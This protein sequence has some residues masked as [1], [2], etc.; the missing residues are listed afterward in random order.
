MFRRMFNIISNVGFSLLNSI[1][2]YLCL[3]P[4]FCILLK[5]QICISVQNF[6]QNHFLCPKS[7]FLSPKSMGWVGGWV[8][9]LAWYF[10]FVMFNLF[11]TH[12]KLM[13][14]DLCQVKV[15]HFKKEHKIRRYESQ[16]QGKEEVAGQIPW[17]FF[18]SSL[19]QFRLEVL[20]RVINISVFMGGELIYQK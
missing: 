13:Y 2:G 15:V 9:K 10:W 11:C 19:P 3:N 1:V 8:H 5:I 20:K 18:F 12:H 4:V 6:R 14:Y 7:H 17:C 16:S